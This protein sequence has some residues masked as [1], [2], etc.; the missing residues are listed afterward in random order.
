MLLTGQ[1]QTISSESKN[2]G[3][4]SLICALL[5]C[6]LLI[7]ALLRLKVIEEMHAHSQYCQ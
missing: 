5:I 2:I 7:C 1:P 4:I 6:A 3:L